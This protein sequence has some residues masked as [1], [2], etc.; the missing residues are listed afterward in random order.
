[1]SATFIAIL[2]FI[3]DFLPAFLKNDR[4]INNQSINRN[5]SLFHI[6]TWSV[7]LLV[8]YMFPST[9]LSARSRTRIAFQLHLDC[10]LRDRI[11]ALV[12]FSAAMFPLPFRFH[13]TPGFP[14]FRAQVSV[15]YVGNFAVNWPLSTVTA[16]TLSNRVHRKSSSRCVISLWLPLYWAAP[17]QIQ[18]APIRK[19]HI[20]PRLWNNGNYIN[21]LHNV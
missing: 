14:S 12:L 4:E 13:Q 8:F 9:Y 6:E 5:G 18:M 7:C 3:F 10:F 11:V 19:R 2:P 1:M 20:S 17:T 21:G 16:S 15:I